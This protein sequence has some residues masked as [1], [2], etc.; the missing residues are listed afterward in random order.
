[1]SENILVL[2]IGTPKTGTTALQKFLYANRD[3]LQK[4]GWSYPYTADIAVGGNVRVKTKNGAGLYRKDI[5]LDTKATNWLK[6]WDYILKELENYN[7]IISAEEISTRETIRLITE[8]KKQYDNVKV[9]V[10]LRRQDHYIESLWNQSIKGQR[11]NCESIDEWEKEFFE[12]DTSLDYF[13]LNYY[14]W[15]KRISDVV[16]KENVIVRAYETQQFK[17]ERKDII[18][19]FFAALDIN[20]NWSNFAHV[21]RQNKQLDDNLLEIKRVMN[22]VLKNVNVSCRKQCCDSVMELSPLAAE[23]KRYL[24]RIKRC[25]IIEKYQEQNELVAR[26]YLHREDGVLFYDNIETEEARY[27]QVASIEEDIIRVFTKLFCEQNTRLN[28][29]QLMQTKGSRKIACFGAGDIGL[30]FLEKEYVPVDIIIDND[31]AKTQSGI[32]KGK[33][34]QLASTVEDW[35]NYFVVITCSGKWRIEIE[36]QLQ[37]YGLKENKDYIWFFQYFDL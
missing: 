33:P 12:S 27:A 30:K 7:V 25:E 32:W 34:I 13:T 20:V 11:C 5:I 4:Y 29:L 19:D 31:K 14:N 22:K 9:L 16:G 1:M 15:L 10:Y 37:S 2:H 8:I 17:G 35:S 26:E 28:I 3:I 36:E 21:G 24:S 18:S 23:K 6:F